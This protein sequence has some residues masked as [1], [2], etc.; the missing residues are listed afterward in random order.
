MFVHRHLGHPLISL[1]GRV[2][3]RSY[4]P[5]ASASDP[6]FANGGYRPSRESG[7]EWLARVV[8]RTMENDDSPSAIAIVGCG[9]CVESVSQQQKNGYKVHCDVNP[10]PIRVW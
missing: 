9:G 6:R 2:T 1:D 8:D 10:I 5:Q 4:E 7:I 3:K